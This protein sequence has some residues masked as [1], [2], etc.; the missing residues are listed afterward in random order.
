[1]VPFLLSSDPSVQRCALSLVHMIG[2]PPS[3]GSALLTKLAGAVA[4]IFF[5]SLHR[6]AE[7]ESSTGG[8]LMP[9]ERKSKGAKTASQKEARV[10]KSETYQKHLIQDI[11][12]CLCLV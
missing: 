2:F 3:L 11:S 7:T 10:E 8:K 4:H 6:K 12:F 1:M 9:Q 5:S